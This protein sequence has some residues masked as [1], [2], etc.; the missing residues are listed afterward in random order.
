MPQRGAG[1]PERKWIPEEVAQ[2][3]AIHRVLEEAEP[4]D[5]T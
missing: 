3:L 2:R 4:S 5:L 1:P